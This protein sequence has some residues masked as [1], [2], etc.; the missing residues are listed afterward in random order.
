MQKAGRRT[1]GALAFGALLLLL[2]IGSVGCT[3]RVLVSH[4]SLEP[5]AQKR[6]GNVLVRPFADTRR[7][8]RHIGSHIATYEGVQVNERLTKYFVEALQNAGYNAVLDS[9]APAD[10]AAQKQ[11]DAVIDGDVN[12]F[13]VGAFFMIWNRVGVKVKATNPA[14]QRVVWEKL[15]RGGTSRVFWLGMTFEFDRI[16]RLGVTDELDRATQ[17]FASDDFY[18]RAIKKR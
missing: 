16:V 5:V 1:W 8:T 9:A 11:Y 12:E 7:D 14:D 4:A 18:N 2:A 15:I 3:T 6:Q 13:H 17:E 10:A